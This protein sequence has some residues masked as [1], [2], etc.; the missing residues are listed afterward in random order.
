MVELIKDNT[1]T[2][3]MG[4]TI[5]VSRSMVEDYTADEFV[6]ACNQLKFKSEAHTT[7]AEEQEKLRRKLAGRKEEIFL[8][9]KKIVDE[10][11]E[12]DMEERKNAMEKINKAKD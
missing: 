8:L 5:R 11:Y 12:K 4:K 2:K 3:L 6:N 7:D 10:A 9:A 1:S